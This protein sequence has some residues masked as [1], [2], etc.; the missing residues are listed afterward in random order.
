MKFLRSEKFKKDYKK[1]SSEIQGR[2][3][4][5]VELFEKDQ[6]HP[7]LRLKKL[8]GTENI[9]ELSINMKFRAT[10]EYISEGILFRRVGD[11]DILESP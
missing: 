9:W 4:E 6:R 1:L 5:K 3:Y 10:F 11:H 7:S 8:Q 2:F